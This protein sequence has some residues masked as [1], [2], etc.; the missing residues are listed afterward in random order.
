[1]DDS[2]LELRNTALMAAIEAA[3]TVGVEPAE[4]VVKRAESFLKFLKGE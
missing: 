3:R 1:M 4:V 2:D